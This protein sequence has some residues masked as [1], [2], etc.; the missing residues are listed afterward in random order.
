MDAEKIGPAV[1]SS[2]KSDEISALARDYVEISLDSVLSAGLLREIPIIKT[3][4]ALGHL[5]V[6]IN[7]RIFA[8][9]LLQF[10]CSLSDLSQE[11][12][13]SMADRLDE[14]EG[15]RHQVGERL[16]EILDRVDSHEKPEMLARVFRGYA[17][18]LINFNML[19]R[20]NIA[21][22]RLPHY[23]IKLVRKFYSASDEERLGLP[24]LALNAFVNAGLASPSS[25]WG[26]LVYS[27]TA[28]CHAFIEL[29]LDR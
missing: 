6:S 8:K 3:I 24:D 28:V 5:G 21:I 17:L 29:E 19:C 27:P 1:I 18:N 13:V 20:L 14:E 16:I 7:D 4:A 23:E 9:K 26:T 25:G 12:R 22:E 2:V 15:F 10:L 11:E